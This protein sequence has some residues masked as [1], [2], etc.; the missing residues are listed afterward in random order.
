MTISFSTSQLQQIKC[1]T[2]FFLLLAPILFVV[3]EFAN[4]LSSVFPFLLFFTGWFTWTFAEYILHRF[5]NHAK[6]VNKDNSIVQRH[7]HHHTH[8]TEISVSGKQR[9]IMILIGIALIVFSLWINEYL[10]ILAGL[11][12]GIFWFFLMHYFLHQKW[13]QKIFPRLL[14]YH[15]VH[16]CKEP[17]ACFGIS[18][19]WWDFVFG[20][21]PKKNK[22]LSEKVIAFYYKKEKRRKKRFSIMSM[23]DE[24]LTERQKWDH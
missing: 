1:F 20:T 4:F 11:E 13:A 2:I 22:E 17:D 19:I 12:T 21:T 9:F 8:P 5:W 24:K 3:I 14:N 15:L 10:L 6:G 23:I 16:H 7:H 18:T